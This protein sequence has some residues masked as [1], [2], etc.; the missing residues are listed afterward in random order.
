ME[1]EGENKWK[2]IKTV[3]L[4]RFWQNNTEKLLT[5]IFSYLKIP[6]FLAVGS[7]RCTGSYSWNF[8]VLIRDLQTAQSEIWRFLFEDFTL[9]F[10]FKEMCDC[11]LDI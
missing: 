5:R 1:G 3:I 4:K 6:R 7:L 10:S 8:T 2:F 11:N 9:C